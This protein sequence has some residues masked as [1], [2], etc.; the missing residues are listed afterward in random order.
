MAAAAKAMSAALNTAL[1][2]VEHANN[3]SQN[4]LERRLPRYRRTHDLL[5]DIH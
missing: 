5:D 4:T 3:Q 1:T 2:P